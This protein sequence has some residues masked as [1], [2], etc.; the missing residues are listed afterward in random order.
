MPTLTNRF[1]ELEIE[2]PSHGQV[3][4]RDDKLPGFALRVTRGCRSYIVECRVNGVNRRITIGKHGVW[5]SK[6][7][8]TKA[9]ELL[10]RM[11]TGQDPRRPK[12][13]SVT[14]REVL[15][16][17]LGSRK[18]RPNTV[19][20]YTHMLRRCLRDWLDMP[21]SKITK[22]MVLTRHRDL[23]R[24]TKAGNSRKE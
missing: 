2:C 5:T 24:L 21:I 9:R 4:Y 16:R 1:V 17:Y 13:C 19:R 18:L 23:T 6:T 20:N 11:S 12:V 15:D 8:R 10:S 7:A 14:L 3:I 22:G